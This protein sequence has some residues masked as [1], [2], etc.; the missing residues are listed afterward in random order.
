MT[1][2]E[3]ITAVKLLQHALGSPRNDDGSLWINGGMSTLEEICEKVLTLLQQAQEPQ[4]RR[5]NDK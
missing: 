2:H 5:K 3:A 4:H 1:N